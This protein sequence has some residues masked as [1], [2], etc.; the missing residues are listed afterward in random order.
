M[1]SQTVYFNRSSIRTR[2][3]LLVHEYEYK[4]ESYYFGTHEYE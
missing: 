1:I 4:Y 2:T 3:W